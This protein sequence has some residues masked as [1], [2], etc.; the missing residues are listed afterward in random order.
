MYDD[1]LDVSLSGEHIGI[2][3]P[4]RK[5]ARFQFD[6]KICETYLGQPLLSVALPVKNRAYSE[7]RTNAWF[8]GLLPEGQRLDKVCR[9]IGCDTADYMNILSIIGWE[10]AGAVSIAKPNTNN[11]AP[12]R[13]DSRP[14]Y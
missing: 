9:E 13:C 1:S 10:C 11:V 5:G 7:G 6:E 14:R 12:L 4:T 8:R 2:L 3:V